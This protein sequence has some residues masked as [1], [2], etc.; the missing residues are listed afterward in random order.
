MTHCNARDAARKIR[1]LRNIES[2]A[3]PD[4]CRQNAQASVRRV[5]A[6]CT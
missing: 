1:V 5:A 2:C 3:Y 6:K 4:L